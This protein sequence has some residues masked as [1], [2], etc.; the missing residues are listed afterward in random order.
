M[1]VIL[2]PYS[3]FSYIWS[4]TF[5][6]NMT[7]LSFHCFLQLDQFVPYAHGVNAFPSCILCI[8]I[9]FAL[10]LTCFLGLIAR[11]TSGRIFDVD[12]FKDGRYAA[13]TFFG[14]AMAGKFVSGF[15]H[16]FVDDIL[17]RA[18]G[19]FII[20]MCV[21]LGMLFCIRALY[22]KLYTLL[23]IMIYGS[24]AVLNLQLYMEILAPN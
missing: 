10:F 20:N 4:S 12:H 17:N 13:Y 14:L 11:I 3:T 6:D 16:G 23:Y 9:F 8:L 21:M 7:Y 5:A 24:K 15:F 2:K 18:F 19:L 1:Q 22:S